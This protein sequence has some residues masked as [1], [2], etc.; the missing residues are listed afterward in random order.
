VLSGAHVGISFDLA[1]SDRDWLVDFV[2][3]RNIRHKHV[4][5]AKIVLLSAAASV[6]PRSS[7]KPMA[8]PA[9][10]RWQKHF[11]QEGVDGL[12][13]AFLAAERRASRLSP[14]NGEVLVKARWERLRPRWVR[15]SLQGVLRLMGQCDLSPNSGGIA[16]GSAQP[17]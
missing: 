3:A 8:K 15:A 6:W 17:R 12:P 7:V 14:R 4:W 1:A 9:V 13:Q 5:R 2:S 11:I 16:P 10:W